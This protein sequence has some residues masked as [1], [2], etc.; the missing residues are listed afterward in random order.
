MKQSK[1]TNKLGFSNHNLGFSNH[2]E[3]MT[4]L[5]MR[6][7][8]SKALSF[9]CSK[10]K[11]R[12]NYSEISVGIGFGKVDI[13]FK[14]DNKDYHIALNHRSI[15]KHLQECELIKK[16]LEPKENATDQVDEMIKESDWNND[17]L[18]SSAIN[19]VKKTIN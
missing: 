18:V 1:K 5:E 19:K 15:E 9:Y 6:N 12:F 2:S 16:E 3:M 13:F 10:Y 4:L 8:I 14:Y 7:L 17:E 11:K